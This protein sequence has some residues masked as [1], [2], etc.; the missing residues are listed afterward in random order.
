VSSGRLVGAAGTGVGMLAA[1]L[2][3]IR[4]CRGLDS[5]KI[6]FVGYLIMFGLGS[7]EL[8]HVFLG[9]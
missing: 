1:G 6:W 9:H 3:R 2:V 5:H 4:C 7:R 8:F